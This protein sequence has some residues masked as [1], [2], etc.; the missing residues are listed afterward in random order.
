MLTLK[1]HLL[2]TQTTKAPPS[3]WKY[4]NMETGGGSQDLQWPWE[5]GRGSKLAIGARDAENEKWNDPYESSNWWFPLR[6]APGSLPHSL[7]R[8]ARK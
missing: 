6:G 1:G 4:G 5:T 7:L 8:P 3:V 2:K